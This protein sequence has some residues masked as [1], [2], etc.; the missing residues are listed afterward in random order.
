MPADKKSNKDSS[1]KKRARSPQPHKPERK[2]KQV[3][4]EPGKEY[5]G[6]ELLPQDDE[7]TVAPESALG[8]A[9]GLE[10]VDGDEEDI[11]ELAWPQRLVVHTSPVRFLK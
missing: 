8:E 6:D 3:E 7:S 11:S 10:D 1:S 2:R 9:Q 4:P 5:T